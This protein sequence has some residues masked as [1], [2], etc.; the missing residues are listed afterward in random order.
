MYIIII[1]F[2]NVS[3]IYPNIYILY[4]YIYIYIYIHIY[5]Y[6]YIYKQTRLQMQDVTQ[7]RF[8]SVLNRF[9]FRVLFLLDWLQ[10]QG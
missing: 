9:E 3:A 8:L 6:I 2:R 4:I 5:I 7:G 10:Y 1:L